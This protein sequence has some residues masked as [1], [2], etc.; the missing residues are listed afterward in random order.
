LIIEKIRRLAHGLRDF[1]HYRLRI[2]L[3]AS[4]NRAYRK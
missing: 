3:A 2:L 1:N 4:A